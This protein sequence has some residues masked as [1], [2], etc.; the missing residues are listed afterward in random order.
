MERNNSGEQKYKLVK[1]VGPIWYN[2]NKVK[3][4]GRITFMP[5]HYF[6][7]FCFCFDVALLSKSHG[8]LFQQYGFFLHVSYIWDC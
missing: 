1:A 6:L 2:C 7:E 4:I 8:A 5:H 3:R